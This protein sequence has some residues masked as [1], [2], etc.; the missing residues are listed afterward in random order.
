MARVLPITKNPTQRCRGA[1]NAKETPLF[2]LFFS[3]FFAPLR[4]CVGFSRSESPTKLNTTPNMCTGTGLSI[5]V[6]AH[7][8]ALGR[9]NIFVALIPNQVRNPEQTGYIKSILPK[10][11]ISQQ[12][13]GI[14]KANI[15]T[16]AQSRF[17]FIFFHPKQCH[18]KIALF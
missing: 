9:R 14:N 10:P 8:T 15:N 2:K 4:L 11:L 16:R 18:D 7:V 13:S 12:N 1:E 3:A 5:Q 6:I 17:K